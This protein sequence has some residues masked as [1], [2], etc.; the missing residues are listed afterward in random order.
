MASSTFLTNMNQHHDN[1]K[2]ERLRLESQ[3]LPDIP[4]NSRI[5]L[6]FYSMVEVNEHKIWKT[7]N[8]IAS[9]H[10]NLNYQSK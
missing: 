6:I 8:P 1:N 7:Q 3:I 10:Y 4:V 9:V 5:R 2:Y